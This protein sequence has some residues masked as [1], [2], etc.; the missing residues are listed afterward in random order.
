MGRLGAEINMWG[1]TAVP[2]SSSYV[3]GPVQLVFVFANISSAKKVAVA[4][5]AHH[6]TSS[7]AVWL[8]HPSSISVI[9]DQKEL[10]SLGF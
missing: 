3:G 4:Q 1:G 2:S 10:S 6:A 7:A 9:V 8:Y 5:H